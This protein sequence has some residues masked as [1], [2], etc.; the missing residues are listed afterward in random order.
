M[1]KAGVVAPHYRNQ[2]VLYAKVVNRET[3]RYNKKKIPFG[4]KLMLKQASICRI[5][6]HLI[7]FDIKFPIHVAQRQS[8]HP[9]PPRS[10][11]LQCNE[12][13]RSSLAKPSPY[14]SNAMTPATPTA[15][16]NATF[17]LTLPAPD[18]SF[19]VFT[20]AGAPESAAHCNSNTG[21]L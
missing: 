12:S 20:E 13:F 16:A 5:T 7:L 21:L 8:S 18:S 17:D 9:S 1:S 19:S 14:P 15:T 3:G 11:M 6:K 10:F 4:I 2:F